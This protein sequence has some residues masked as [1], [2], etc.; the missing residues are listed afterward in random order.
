MPLKICVNN[1]FQVIGK[2]NSFYAFHLHRSEHTFLAASNLYHLPLVIRTHS[3]VVCALHFAQLLKFSDM[4]VLYVWCR[5]V[6]WVYIYTLE[7]SK[8]KYCTLDDCCSLTVCK[9]FK[10]QTH[11]IAHEV[12]CVCMSASACKQNFSILNINKFLHRN[13]FWWRC[14]ELFMSLRTQYRIAGGGKERTHWG[15]GQW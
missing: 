4:W 12:S 13:R 5:C 14:N 3:M 1:A 6:I 8:C 7:K 9:Q 15:W 11:T 10:L 2:W